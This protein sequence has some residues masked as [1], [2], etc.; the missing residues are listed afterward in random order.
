[1]THEEIKKLANEAE[2]F[3]YIEGQT[4]AIKRFATLIRNAALDEAA[5]AIDK[6]IDDGSQP[7]DD[8]DNGWL[9]G[10][11]GAASKIRELKEK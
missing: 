8:W 7:I 3:P 11:V 10:N 9:A 6:R 5:K 2:L 1:M 4:E